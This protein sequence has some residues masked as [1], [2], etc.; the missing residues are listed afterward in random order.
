MGLHFHLVW[1]SHNQ[2]HTGSVS[3]L[4]TPMDSMVRV[5]TQISLELLLF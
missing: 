5:G 2:N 1:D 4:L 3:G